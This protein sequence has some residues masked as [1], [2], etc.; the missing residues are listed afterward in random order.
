MASLTDWKG[1]DNATS[2]NIVQ[3]T[4][5]CSSP[6]RS[7]GSAERLWEQGQAPRDVLP[8]ETQSAL[9]K[10][11]AELFEL[12][13][14]ERPTII[15]TA[16][17]IG[18]GDN[19]HGKGEAF[20]LD[21]FYWGDKKF[22]MDQYKK[23]RRFYIGINAHLFLF[24]SQ[25]LNTHYP[26]HYDHFHVDFNFTYSYRETSNAQTLRP[27]PALSLAI[28][29]F[30]PRQSRSCLRS[31][32]PAGI[33]RESA[34]GGRSV[35]RSKVDGFN[36]RPSGDALQRCRFAQRR[37]PLGLRGVLKCAPGAAKDFVFAAARAANHVT[38]EIRQGEVFGLAGAD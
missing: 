6:L 16:G 18:D 4:R 34:G 23:D 30:M 37:G 29:A 26:N 38:V 35:Q 5:W 10:C 17:T 9:E 20:D 32:H 15:L 24:C 14:R 13:G 8:K 3:R 11:F 12:W 2:G 22:M 27:P 7:V 25:V 28:L 31:W 1:Y 19:S 36:R 33:A 21:G